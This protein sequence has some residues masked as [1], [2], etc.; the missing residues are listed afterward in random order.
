M[1]RPV[2]AKKSLG[3][4]FL[5][6]PNYQ[7]KIVGALDLDDD[8]ELIE[9]GPGTG[10]ITQHMV[11][12][13]RRFTAIELDDQLAA[14][15]RD[16]FSHVPSF[17][18]VH[19]DVMQ[20]PLTAVS[21]HIAA[22]KVVGN[23]P[24]NIT[25]PLLFRLLEREHRPALIVVMVQKEVADRIVAAPGAKDF[26]ALSVGVQ[27]VASAERLFVVPRGAFRPAPSV[28]SA[29]VR[30]VPRRPFELTADEEQDL[31][32]LTRSAFGM[33]RKQLQKIL[34]SSDSYGL[35][36]DEVERLGAQL[37]RSLTSRPEELAASEFVQLSRLL[38]QAGYPHEG[39]TT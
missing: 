17:H 38:R 25:S 13:V 39:M 31:R 7:K 33:R 23:I 20:V 4:N 12:R 18:L 14:A 6:D 22:A 9:I 5:V 11:A 26:G 28:D 8:D 30:I 2:R 35:G 32:T 24:Y 37:G 19:Q 21:E 15:L 27:A 36:A 1:S 16:R 34:R 29:V 3:Q 10:A